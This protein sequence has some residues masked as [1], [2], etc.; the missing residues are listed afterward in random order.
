LTENTDKLTGVLMKMS[1][2]LTVLDLKLAVPLDANVKRTIRGAMAMALPQ[3]IS[4]RVIG[5]SSWIFS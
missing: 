2:S 5:Y 4:L 1:N 3:T